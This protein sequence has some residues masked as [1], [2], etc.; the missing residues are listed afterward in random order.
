MQWYNARGHPS[1]AW[2]AIHQAVGSILDFG[3]IFFSCPRRPIPR[4]ESLKVV[5]TSFAQAVV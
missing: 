1:S 4:E 3:T 2:K 5:K